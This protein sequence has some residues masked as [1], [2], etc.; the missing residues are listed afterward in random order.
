MKMFLWILAILI[1]VI[2]SSESN[3]AASN[4]EIT[5]GSSVEQDATNT[6]ILSAQ[7][8]FVHSPYFATAVFLPSQIFFL[9]SPD[10]SYAN[11]NDIAPPYELKKFAI[12]S[13]LSPPSFASI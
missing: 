13:G 8:I 12:K 6:A 1:S 9:S 3:A 5:Q 7:N 4:A 2:L 10:L 11:Q